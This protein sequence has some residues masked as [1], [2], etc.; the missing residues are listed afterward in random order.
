[1]DDALQVYFLGGDERK[2]IGQVETQLSSEYGNRSGACAVGLAGTVFQHMAEKIFVGS[3]GLH[4]A[5]LVCRHIRQKKKGRTFRN[6]PWADI[7]N[8][9]YQLKI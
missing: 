5:K 3:I 7:N 8:R 2:A 1:M 4:V 9:Q 6:G